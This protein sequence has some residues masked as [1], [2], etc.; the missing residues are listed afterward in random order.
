MIGRILGIIAVTL[1]LSGSALALPPGRLPLP[2]TGATEVQGY[3]SGITDSAADRIVARINAANA[4]CGWVNKVY[5]VDCL[6][7][8]YDQIARAL[9][10]GADYRTIRAALAAAQ[11]DLRQIAGTY[12]DPARPAVRP[13][14]PRGMFAAEAKRPLTPVRGETVAQAGRIA[15]RVLTETATL[16]LRSAGTDR[17]EAQLARIAGAINSGKVLL[18]S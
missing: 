17:Q 1:A 13:I 4:Y 14:P 16:L 3:G 8:Q 10:R 5:A 2:P 18:R 7:D 6:S 15:R 9:P 11:K 12:A